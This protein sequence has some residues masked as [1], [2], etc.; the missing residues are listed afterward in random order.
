MYYQLQQRPNL[1]VRCIHSK[2]CRSFVITTVFKVLS[3]T[4]L[5]SLFHAVSTLR[6]KHEVKRSRN[7]TR[8]VDS[9]FL[10]D[11]DGEY[12]DCAQ[13]ILNLRH[14]CIIYAV[15]LLLMMTTVMV[16]MV[17][18]MKV[19]VVKNY[20]ND[21]DDDDSNYD[22]GDSIDMAVL[23]IREKTVLILR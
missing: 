7:G 5:A 21:D 4:W 20:G 18:E 19:I 2:S 3:K 16:M 17:R 14:R 1:H 6:K 15:L 23:V 10:R 9:N 22:D 12:D 8:D 13:A 11:D